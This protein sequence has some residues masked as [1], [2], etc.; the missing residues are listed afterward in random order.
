M[1]VAVLVGYLNEKR[2]SRCGTALDEKEIMKL[3]M[4]VPD[5]LAMTRKRG[6][7][8]FISCGW[9][10]YAGSGHYKGDCLVYGKCHLIPI[11][12]IV[13]PLK[14]ID[15]NYGQDDLEALL[16]IHT[17]NIAVEKDAIKR[18]KDIR[19]IIDDYSNSAGKS[20]NEG[21]SGV[22]TDAQWDTECYLKR[23]GGNKEFRDAVLQII[24]TNIETTKKYRKERKA[25][26]KEIKDK[27][28]NARYSPPLPFFRR[29]DH[30]KVGDNVM[31]KQDD[32]DYAEVTVDE[33]VGGNSLK[34]GDNKVFIGSIEV[35]LKAEW[36]YFEKDEER[37]R[38]WVKKFESSQTVGA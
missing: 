36:D 9:C 37:Y 10:R 32:S 20:A 28:T 24:D 4:A 22:P 11:P 6:D 26:V 5:E 1:A 30:F 33:I 13:A 19:G 17:E 35:M 18:F 16:L 14:V 23:F 12:V 34:I 29:P 2:T 15:D 25:L 7:T 27:L 31:F 21:F 38:W 3:F 8:T